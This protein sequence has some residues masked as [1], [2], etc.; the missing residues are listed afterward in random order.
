MNIIKFNNAEFEVESYYRNT[1]FSNDTIQSNG[2]CVIKTDDTDLLY[3]VAES[4]ITSI[5]IIKDN[6]VIYNL[7]DI[8]A[9]IE[10]IGESFSGDRVYINVNFIFE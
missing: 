9:H 2:N 5:Q 6:E 4:S 3:E 1:N 10:N 7:T 8:T